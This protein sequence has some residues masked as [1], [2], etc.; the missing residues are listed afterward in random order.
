MFIP[1]ELT[2]VVLLVLGKKCEVFELSSLKPR[3]KR[4]LGMALAIR[5]SASARSML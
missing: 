3:L 1:T 5:V 2:S 4:G